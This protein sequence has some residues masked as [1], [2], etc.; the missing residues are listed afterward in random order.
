MAPEER[1]TRKPSQLDSNS[2]N[3]LLQNNVR[4]REIIAPFL[5][6]FLILALFWVVFSGKFDRFHITLG[7]IACMIVAGLS[8]DLLFP[9]G[10]KP[11]FFMSCLRFCGYIPWLL[12]QVFIANLHV[13][14]LTF[15]PRMMDLIDPKIIEFDSILK[16]DVSRT[17]MANS[18]T[19]TPGTIT[20]N[21]SM[22]GKYTVHCIDDKSGRSLPGEMERR[23]EKVFKN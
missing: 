22:L 10:V 9:T 16:S 1:G 12:Y 17:T 23:I 11:G 15:H 3:R 4:G 8:H 18:I 20:V 21:V 5:I 13:L 6:T 2:G 7:I 19:L 14:Y